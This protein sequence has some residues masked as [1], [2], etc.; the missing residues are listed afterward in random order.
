MTVKT[1][2]Q[3]E[4]FVKNRLPE[5]LAKYLRDLRLVKEADVECCAYL[6]IRKFIGRSLVWRVLAR[7]HVP[8]TG[9]YV[10]LLIFRNTTPRIAIELKFG[11]TKISQKDESS[12]L[13]ALEQLGVNKAYWISVTPRRRSNFETASNPP[14]KNVM[15]Y[16]VVG[17]DFAMSDI[18]YEEWKRHRTQFRSNMK[19]GKKAIQE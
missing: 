14:R 1:L 6:H 16:C 8:H 19:C 11:P 18:E 17:L 15:H 12:L 9:H 7:K 4:S 13:K 5:L 3:L 2:Q 10:D